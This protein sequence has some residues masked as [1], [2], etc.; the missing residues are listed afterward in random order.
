MIDQKEKW[1]RI[2]SNWMH[3]LPPG[4][5]GVEELDI[6]SRLI[7]KYAVSERPKVLILGVTPEY[8]DLFTSH[9]VDI[10]IVDQSEEMLSVVSPFR[11]YDSDEHTVIADWFDYLPTVKS[12]FDFIIADLVQGNISYELQPVFYELISQALNNKGYFIERVLTFRSS[13]SI[14]NVLELYEKYES[15]PINSITL[16]T[17]MSEVFFVSDLTFKSKKV[18]VAQIYQ[19]M[20]A[21]TDKYNSLK[22]YVNLLEKYIF[23]A[24]ATWYYGKGWDEISKYYYQHLQLIEEIPDCRSEYKGFAYIVITKKREG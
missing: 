21:H 9:G 11:K 2:S 12:Q 19:H 22:K 15:L 16:N 17:M 1:E 13:S 8:R 24:E 18:E 20:L 23:G 10:T 5:P 7:K 6:V 14:K 3:F 4:R